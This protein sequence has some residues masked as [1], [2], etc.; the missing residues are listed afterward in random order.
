[1]SGKICLSILNEDQ[2]WRPAITIKQ[3]L[4]GIQDLLDNPNDKD[5]AQLDAMKLY[6]DDIVAYKA[7]IRD[8]ACKNVPD[9]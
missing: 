2:G 7:K 6:Q 1:M 5:P 3:M 9:S 8:Q 4:I